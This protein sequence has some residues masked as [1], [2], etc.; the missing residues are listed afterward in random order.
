[1]GEVVEL[2]GGGREGGREGGDVPRER[3]ILTASGWR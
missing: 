1:M 3:S 2:E